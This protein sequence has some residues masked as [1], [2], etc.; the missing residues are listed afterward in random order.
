MLSG[1]IDSSAEPSADSVDFS[2]DRDDG[3]MIARLRQWGRFAPAVGRGIIDRVGRDRLAVGAA[4]V[5]DG[6]IHGIAGLE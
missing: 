1:A 2:L 3:Q 6:K 5:L 4:A